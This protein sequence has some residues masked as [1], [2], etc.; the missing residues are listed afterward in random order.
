MRPI[1]IQNRLCPHSII[2]IIDEKR[3]RNYKRL[4]RVENEKKIN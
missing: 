4:E 3:S 2:A 1:F